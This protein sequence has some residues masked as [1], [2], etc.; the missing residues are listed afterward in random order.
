MRVI[1]LFFLI[2]FFFGLPFL[3]QAEDKFKY[4]PKQKRDPFAPL[5]GPAGEYLT[6]FGDVKAIGD[7]KLE[8][9][10][11]DPNGESYAII[12]GE[13]VKEG[14]YLGG[15]L[16]SKVNPKEVIILLEGQEFSLILIEEEGGG[17]RG[18]KT[19]DENQ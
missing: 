7:M 15:V 18:E 19:K 10:I 1:K 8:G 6:P 16:V 11:W 13:I 14:D 2:L 5:I 17:W 9:I 3:L 12:N 4:D